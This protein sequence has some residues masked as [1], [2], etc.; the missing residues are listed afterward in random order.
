MLSLAL[1]RKCHLGHCEAI[2]VTKVDPSLNELDQED[3]RLVEIIRDELL[4]HPPNERKEL[5]L[6]P[7]NDKH[8]RINNLSGQYGQPMAI[9]ELLK[10]LMSI[11]SESF[12]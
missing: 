1:D 11:Q 10:D 3:P 6:E 7:M 2:F 4:V 9:E 8:K 12:V 5:N